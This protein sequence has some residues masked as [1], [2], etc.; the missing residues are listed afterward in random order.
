[1]NKITINLLSLALLPAL[2]SAPAFAAGCPSLSGKYTCTD[3][4]RLTITQS[5]E[6]GRNERYSIDGLINKRMQLINDHRPHDHEG[7]TLTSFCKDQVVHTQIDHAR[8]RSEFTMT[9]SG[10]MLL[11][12]SGNFM[13]RCRQK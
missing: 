5:L 7:A 6:A 9:K 13:I 11:I 2:C 8:G 1:M 12:S 10:A 3:G 4:K